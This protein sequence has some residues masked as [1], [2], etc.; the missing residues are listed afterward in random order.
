MVS[1][2]FIYFSQPDETILPCTAIVIR[3]QRLNA[4]GREKDVNVLKLSLHYSTITIPKET[5]L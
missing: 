5:S 4:E 2:T 1:D 3:S